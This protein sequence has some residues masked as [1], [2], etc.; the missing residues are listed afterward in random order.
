LQRLF[1]AR[2]EVISLSPTHAVSN[3][4]GTW[5]DHRSSWYFPVFQ[6]SGEFPA[7]HRRQAKKCACIISA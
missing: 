3:A 4:E 5:G 2:L 1:R 7:R 6:R